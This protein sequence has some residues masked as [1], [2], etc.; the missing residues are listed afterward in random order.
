MTKAELQAELAKLRQTE[1]RILTGG[2]AVTTDGDTVTEATLF[3][4]QE[5][6]KELES[7]LAWATR[8]RNAVSARFGGRS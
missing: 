8:R 3:R 1:S 2:Q 6:I 4:V 5:K 7:R